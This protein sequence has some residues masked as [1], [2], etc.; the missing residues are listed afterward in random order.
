MTY[1]YCSVGRFILV[2][3]FVLFY[4]LSSQ[5]IYVLAK[6]RLS[7]VYPAKKGKKK[8]PEPQ[9]EDVKEGGNSRFKKK[10]AAS[11]V[12]AVADSNT[13]AYE[14]LEEFKG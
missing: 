4:L 9:K 14:I 7:Y 1:L 3:L 5:K 10:A 12:S 2:T 6:S 11:N 13:E 8:A